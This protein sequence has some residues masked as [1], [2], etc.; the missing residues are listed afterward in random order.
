MPKKKWEKLKE[1]NNEMI[2]S[3]HLTWPAKC[4]MIRDELN[5]VQCISDEMFPC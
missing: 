2:K 3:S 4:H 1:N 5:F